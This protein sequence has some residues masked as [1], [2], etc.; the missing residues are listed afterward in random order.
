MGQKNELCY[1]DSLH[2]RVSGGHSY[3]KNL[4]IVSGVPHDLPT[5]G[6]AHTRGQ[7]DGH[8]VAKN[9]PGDISARFF[10]RG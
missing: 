1:Q 10:W 8:L 5:F 6:F 9:G 2:K 4:K 7:E 3:N